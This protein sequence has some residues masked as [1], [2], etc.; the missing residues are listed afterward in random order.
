METCLQFTHEEGAQTIRAQRR[1][2]TTSFEEDTGQRELPLLHRDYPGPLFGPLLLRKQSKSNL[3]G[4]HYRRRLKQATPPWADL[5]AIRELYKQAKRLTKLTGRL[6]S[7]DHVVPLKGE[8]VCGLHV[9]SNLKVLLHAE[10]VSKGNS[11][12]G[13]LEMF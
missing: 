2:A 11:F 4:R 3:R 10:N 6:H 8:C 13:Q 12:V 1:R 5:A 9:E 7:V